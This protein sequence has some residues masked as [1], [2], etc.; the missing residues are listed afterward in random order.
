MMECCGTWERL[1]RTVVLIRWIRPGGLKNFG[2]IR[3]SAILRGA[4]HGDD[5]GWA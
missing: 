5:W 4:T 3:E 2:E 1:E